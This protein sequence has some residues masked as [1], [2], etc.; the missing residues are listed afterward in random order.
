M[1]IFI[2]FLGTIPIVYLI[3]KLRFPFNIVFLRKLKE[4]A[5]SIVRLSVSGFIFFSAENSSLKLS[6]DIEAQKSPVSDLV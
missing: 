5:K 3:V 2:L 1:A 6:L 4:S